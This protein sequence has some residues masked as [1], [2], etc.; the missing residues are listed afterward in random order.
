MVF[1]SRSSTSKQ[2]T[3]E[4]NWNVSTPRL[5]A[6]LQNTAEKKLWYLLAIGI[7]KPKGIKINT[8]PNKFVNMANMPT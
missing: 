4:N 8:F 1:N 7:K 5:K 6:K 3:L 2:P